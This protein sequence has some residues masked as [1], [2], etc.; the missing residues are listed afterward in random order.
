MAAALGGNLDCLKYAIEHGCIP[1]RNA[2]IAAAKNGHLD[3][4]KYLHSPPVSCPLTIYEYLDAAIEG[5]LDCLQY[6]CDNGC[7]TV[8]IKRSEV[9]KTNPCYAYIEANGLFLD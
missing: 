2:C 7:P 1:C 4:L 6:L 9:Q 8:K 5:W 3:C